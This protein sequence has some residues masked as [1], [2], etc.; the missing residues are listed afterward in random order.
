M[1]NFPS[2]W[3]E[4]VEG[5]EIRRINKSLN[6]NNAISWQLF[7]N[8]V[9]IIL[10][11]ILNLYLNS[12]KANQ[13]KWLMFGII[14]FFLLLSALPIIIY[15]FKRI[16]RVNIFMKG[17]DA[18]KLFD[19]DIVYNTM[20]AYEFYEQIVALQQNNTNQNSTP[21]GNMT[22]LNGNIN[23][24]YK[25]EVSYYVNK[26]IDELISFNSNLREIV[27]NPIQGG[28]NSKM[29]SKDR[30]LNITDILNNLINLTNIQVNNSGL[31]ASFI[32]AV[33][34]L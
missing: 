1:A 34:N 12:L 32:S 25:I 14:L 3:G 4:F 21:Q 7:C 33:K 19:E 13:V 24:F 8:I 5:K 16:F 6:T 22:A 18:V 26:A 29:I 10:T 20:M 28:K 11:T 27:Y 17:K 31:F 9:T 2:K 30:V 15:K 23:D